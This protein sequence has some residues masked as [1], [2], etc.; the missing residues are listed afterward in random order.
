MIS[1]K[2]CFTCKEVKLLTEFI[3]NKARPDGVTVYCALC[4]S[5]R[6]KLARQ[7]ARFETLCYYSQNPPFCNCCKEDRLEFLSID[8]ING[9]GKAHIQEI[10]YNLVRW[11]RKNNY[12]EGYRVLCMN[13]NFSIGHH[14]YCPHT[15]KSKLLSELPLKH[16]GVRIGAGYPRRLL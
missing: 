11:L 2:K 1:S 12:P 7:R 10:G 14:G 3:K 16:G 4:E 15:T 13:C 6:A 9:G 5:N 8:H